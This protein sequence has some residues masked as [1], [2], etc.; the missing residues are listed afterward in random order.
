MEERRN[1]VARIR[2]LLAL[3]V[4]LM[5]STPS[6]AGQPVWTAVHVY[7][8]KLQPLP[9]TQKAVAMGIGS[10]GTEYRHRRLPSVCRQGQPST[11]AWCCITP[12]SFDVKPSLTYVGKPRLQTPSRTLFGVFTSGRRSRSTVRKQARQSVCMLP[13]SS[14]FAP[15][16][17]SFRPCNSG[18]G[19]PET[20]L[21]QRSTYIITT[22]P[23]TCC[24]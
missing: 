4:L 3:G 7:T 15:E 18:L 23:L 8:A 12:P 13:S 20:W 10:D 24:K 21:E 22:L 5:T 6:S 14:A 19:T 9:P 16:S 1:R 17:C 11:W 2:S